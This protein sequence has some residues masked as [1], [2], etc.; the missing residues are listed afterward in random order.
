MLN[1]NKT[2]RARAHTHTSAPTTYAGGKRDCSDWGCGDEQWDGACCEGTLQCA[3]QSADYWQC[4]PRGDA[5][6][7]STFLPKAPADGSSV[8]GGDG[9]ADASPPSSSL[10][11][12]AGD[13]LASMRAKAPGARVDVALGF[14]TPFDALAADVGAR[15]RFMSEVSAWLKRA[16]GPAEYVLEAGVDQIIKAQ[17]RAPGAAATSDAADAPTV[18]GTVARGH[19][20][21]A[22]GAPL[23][24]VNAAPKALDEAAAG[25]FKSAPVPDAWGPLGSVE[26]HLDFTGGRGAGAAPTASEQSAVRLESARVDGAAAFGDFGDAACLGAGCPPARRRA[27]KLLLPV[28]AIVAIAVGGGLVLAAAGF[29]VGRALAAPRSARE[30]EKGAQLAYMNEL[31]EADLAAAAAAAVEGG[32]DNDGSGAAAAAVELEGAGG[33]GGGAAARVVIPRVRQGRLLVWLG[34]LSGGGASMGGGGGGGGDGEP[35]AA[36]TAAGRRSG[37]GGGGLAGRNWRAE[38][39]VGAPRPEAAALPRAGDSDP[40]AAAAGAAG[41]AAPTAAVS[42]AAVAAAAAAVPVLRFPRRSAGG[43]AAASPAASPAAG[44]GGIA[45]ASIAQRRR[46]SAGGGG[47]PAAVAAA[48]SPPAAAAAAPAADG[49]EQQAPPARGG[50]RSSAGGSAG[51]ALRRSLGR[52]LAGGDADKSQ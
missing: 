45:F 40:G 36:A 37:G 20:V 11:A 25:L 30:A 33:A 43:S 41:A 31:T 26:A 46:S 19:V 39:L 23:Q 2:P 48:A 52:L 49:D 35:A 50:R 9:G 16:A 51:G 24:F 12:F 1:P 38:P 6:R 4:L 3:R 44:A 29:V 7:V 8:E 34:R 14:A 28:G 47:S 15:A 21:F 5:R 10:P 42:P 27:G 22:A 18:D 13:G 17:V 32:S